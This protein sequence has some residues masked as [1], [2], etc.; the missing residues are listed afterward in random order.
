MNTSMEEHR[1]SGWGKREDLSLLYFK[2]C[3]VVFKSRYVW[4]CLLTAQGQPKFQAQKLEKSPMAVPASEQNWGLSKGGRV[5]ATKKA[6][7]M[8]QQRLKKGLEAGIR[9]IKHNVVMKSSTSMPKM[10]AL[11]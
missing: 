8:Q 3:E 1:T 7:I 5:I 9:K 2:L 11:L 4:A 10:L 6:R